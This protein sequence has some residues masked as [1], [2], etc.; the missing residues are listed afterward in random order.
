M[1]N[2][3]CQKFRESVGGK[4]SIMLVGG[5]PLSQDTQK[6]IKSCLNIKLIQGYASTETTGAGCM[7]DPFDESLGRVGAPLLGSQIK[8]IDWKEG[9]YRVTDSPNPRGEMVVG[10][11]SISTGYFK[12]DATTDEAFYSDSENRRWFLTGDIGEAFPDGTFKI[13]DRKKDL[14]KLQFGEYVSLGK[15]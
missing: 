4:L 12:L 6:L 14:I 1:N 5:A 2:I 3:F 11:D 13:I 9:G 7:M 10:S 8:L 15:V